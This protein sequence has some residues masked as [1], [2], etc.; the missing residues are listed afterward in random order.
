MNTLLPFPDF[1]MSARCLAVDTLKK[2]RTEAIVI[3]KTL[4]NHL[5]GWNSH[6]ACKMWN[7][8]T[9][10]LAWYYDIINAICK[11]QGIEEVKTGLLPMGFPVIFPA[12]I[13]NPAFH[14][15]HQSNLLKKDEKH[16]RL[17]F[18]PSVP[19]TLDYLWPVK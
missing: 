5:P 8:Y 9:G 6:P 14:R 16:Y 18:G 10:A 2:Q 17:W 19:K 1:T 15:S 4:K 12:W 3:Y 7:G 11:T 13:G